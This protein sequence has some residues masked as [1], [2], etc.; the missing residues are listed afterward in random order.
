MH[1]P[2]LLFMLAPIT[3]G[4]CAMVLSGLCFP[5]C[6]VMVL[7]LNMMNLRFLLMHGV[8]LGGA[9]AL[10]LQLPT[11]PVTIAV[12][13][14]LVAVLLFSAQKSQTGFGGASSA[15]MV[16]SMAAASLIMHVTDVPAKDTLDLLWGSP[17]A[18]S[19]V[20]LLALGTLFAL[21]VLYFITHFKTIL[22]IFYNRDIARSLGISVHV[23]YTLMVVLVALVV[24]VAM[25]LL[26]AFL[27][28][29]LLILPVLV[30]EC[31]GIQKLCLR[32]A[33]TGLSSA[34]AGYTLAVA[35]NL[36]PGATIA[37]T[38]AILYGTRKLL[39]FIQNKPYV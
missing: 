31:H 3:R 35:F 9:V 28:D 26:G 11:V 22:A 32:S 38:A 36:P 13:L 30:A 37:G 6:G 4:L 7:R 12:N 19:N 17:F 10:A 24:A 5:L 29:A 8:L 25:K 23:H 16:I 21:V 39:N 2:A 34:I 18:L 27:I 20:D 14:V 15:T 33:L 1:N